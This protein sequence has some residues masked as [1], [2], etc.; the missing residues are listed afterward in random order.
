[1]T[2]K[3]IPTV[4]LP[5]QT[6]EPADKKKWINDQLDAGVE[7]NGGMIDKKFGGRNGARTLKKILEERGTRNGHK[8]IA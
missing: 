2:V 6:F 5:E 4:I 3:E 1:M 7:L 8:V